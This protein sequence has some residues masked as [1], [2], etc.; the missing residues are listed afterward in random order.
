MA[1]IRV[2]SWNINGV[3]AKLKK[4]KAALLDIFDQYD[5]LLLQETKIGKKQGKPDKK[6]NADQDWNTI[7]EAF[8]EKYTLVELEDQTYRGRSVSPQKTVYMTYFSSSSEGVAILINKPHTLLKGY[9]EGGEYAWVHVQIGDQKYTF[10][11]VYYRGRG[12]NLIGHLMLKIIYSFLT[13]GSDAFKHRPV[14]GGDF[15]TT[16]DPRLD[17]NNKNS[18]HAPL[19][20][21]LNDFMSIMKLSDVWRK[22]H[23]GARIYTY[24]DNKEIKNKPENEP[25]GPESESESEPENEHKN[26]PNETESEPIMSRLDYVFMLEKD[27]N[28]VN[29]CEILGEIT[30]SD[31]SPV[32]LTLNYPN[33]NDA[34]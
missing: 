20:K 25:N 33:T 34:K 9:S 12:P 16:L 22:K 10:V 8:L 11:S 21:T 6:G 27:V 17:A 2:L 24:V 4:Q 30:L 19:R 26:E 32:S 5:I 28:D 3:K 23:E 7:N 31:H 13:D 18:K 15:N 29:S 14:I 1:D